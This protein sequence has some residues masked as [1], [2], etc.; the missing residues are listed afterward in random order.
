MEGGVKGSADTPSLLAEGL[1]WGYF[2]MQESQATQTVVSQ[3]LHTSISWY[4]QD[5][6]HVVLISDCSPV[7]VPRWKNPSP[8]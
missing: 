4:L 2:F 7:H 1:S 5:A 3:T 8:I 6:I